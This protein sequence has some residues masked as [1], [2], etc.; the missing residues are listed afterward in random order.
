MV[1]VPESSRPTD[2]NHYQPV[3]LIFHVVK[4]RLKHTVMKGSSVLGSSLV[5][6]EVV[7][8]REDDG[9]AVINHG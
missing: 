7:G 8:N 6:A 2:F 9:E 1:Q 4:P 3:A 5:P